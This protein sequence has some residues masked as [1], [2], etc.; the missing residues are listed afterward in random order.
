MN[1]LIWKDTYKIQLDDSIVFG[2]GYDFFG[3]DYLRQEAVG[4]NGN[5]LIWPNKDFRS[6][7]WSLYRDSDGA[8]AFEAFKSE[9]DCKRA[10][11]LWRSDIV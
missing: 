10:A 8:L 4:P 6:E 5:Y 3:L 7:N 1:T 11:E 9:S 2:K